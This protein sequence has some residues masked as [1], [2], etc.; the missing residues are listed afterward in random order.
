[1]AVNFSGSF[2]SPGRLP[3]IVAGKQRLPGLILP[4]QCEQ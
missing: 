1:M 4:S 2:Y 3:E